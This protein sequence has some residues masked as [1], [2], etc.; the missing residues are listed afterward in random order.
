MWIKWLLPLYW[1]RF[2]CIRILSSLFRAK[3]DLI[4]GYE[5]AHISESQSVV[6][7]SIGVTWKLVKMH[8]TYWIRICG[9]GPALVIISPSRDSDVYSSLR[10][11]CIDH[12]E[13]WGG[14]GRGS[15]GTSASQIGK[16][17]YSCWFKKHM[18]FPMPTWGATCW[19]KK[20]LP[21]LMAS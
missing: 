2:S 17:F 6:P 19:I 3:R 8:Q 14:G 7:D 15:L 4:K 18:A 5:M 13:A 10:I 1:S 11:T 16:L 20:P 21:Q 9:M 12:W